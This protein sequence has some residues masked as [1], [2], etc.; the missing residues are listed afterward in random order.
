MYSFMGLNWKDIF[1]DN[2]KWH[3][4]EILKDKG[5]GLK[6]TVTKLK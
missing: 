4:Y 6:K 1:Y 5:E 3:R 2:L